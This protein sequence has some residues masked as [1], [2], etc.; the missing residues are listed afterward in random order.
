MVAVGLETVPP[1]DSKPAATTCR[2]CGGED[3]SFVFGVCRECGDDQYERE[4][5]EDDEP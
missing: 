5:T 1:S 4:P 2:I 3:E